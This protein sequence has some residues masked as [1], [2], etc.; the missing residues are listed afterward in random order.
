MGKNCDQC[1]SDHYGYPNCTRCNCDEKGSLAGDCDYLGQCRCKELVTGLKCD[2]CRQATFGLSH[3]NPHGCTRC[4]CFGRSQEC[5]QSDLSWGQIRQIGARNLTVEYVTPLKR[6]DEEYEYV[7][8]VQMQGA[9]TNNEDSQIE[10]LNELHLIPSSTGNISIGSYVHFEY[11]LYFQL[12]VQFLGD[13]VTSY[14]GHLQYT[15]VSER[16]NRSLSNEILG[17][18][19][20]VQIHSYEGL[21]LDYFGVSFDILS[22]SSIQLTTSSFSRKYLIPNRMSL[23]Q[24][25]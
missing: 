5:Q 13:K 2:T 12:P 21:V 17:Q 10:R 14:A 18:F 16:C 22:M 4:Y 7:V 23:I 9:L 24:W 15:V 25:G 1:A 20:L 8:V 11:P 6:N 19:P 3:S